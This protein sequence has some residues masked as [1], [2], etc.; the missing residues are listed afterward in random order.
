MEAG[1]DRRLAKVGSLLARQPSAGPLELVFERLQNVLDEGPGT[2]L[3]LEL[4]GAQGQ[5]H[6]RQA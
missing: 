5:V 6:R 3:E 2:R 4:A 1:R